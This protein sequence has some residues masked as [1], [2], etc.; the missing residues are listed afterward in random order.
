MELASEPGVYEKFSGAILF[1]DMRCDV[2]E[3][4]FELLKTKKT[5]KGILD[6]GVIFKSGKITGGAIRKA[7]I[8]Q[9]EFSGFKIAD[10]IFRSGTFKEGMIE[11]SYWYGGT[12]ENGYI[13]KIFDKFGRLRG[14]TPSSWNVV[15]SCMTSW[16]YSG[17]FGYAGTQGY[18]ENYSGEVRWKENV[19]TV[20]NA[21]FELNNHGGGVFF[22]NG[23]IVYGTVKGIHVVN[24]VWKKGKFTYGIWENGTWEGGDW[25]DGTWL[26]GV[27]EDGTWDGGAWE[28]GKWLD[29][30]WKR[31]LWK[32]GV[33][34][35][36]D[37]FFGY[38]RSHKE[39]LPGDSPNKW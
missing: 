11:N 32:K 12:W 34:Y 2:E 1:E 38:D 14:N 16:D 20:K 21:D 35:N 3:A 13:T 19:F 17:N 39:H 23:T 33:W 25:I 26:D 24:C 15:N 7:D 28:G 10:S 18:Y 4:T 6:I 27:W 8:E 22:N 5:F 29:G 36:G 31:G 9:C 37:W 30:S